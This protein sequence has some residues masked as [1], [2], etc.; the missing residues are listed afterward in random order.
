MSTLNPDRKPLDLVDP[1]GLVFDVVL[2]I[3]TLFVLNG[4]HKKGENLVTLLGP[5][6][7]LVF[8]FLAQIFIPPY[9]G[10]VWGRYRDTGGILF[11]VALI[12]IMILFVY[13]IA[14]LYISGL[15]LG[16]YL[17]RDYGVVPFVLALVV[18]LCATGIGGALGIK[19]YK[20]SRKSSNSSGPNPPIDANKVKPLQR[21]PGE[22]VRTLFVAVLVCFWVDFTV[23]VSTDMDVSAVGAFFFVTVSGVIPLRLLVEFQ[24]PRTPI[25]MVTGTASLTCFIVMV[26]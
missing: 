12:F 16:A 21:Q 18:G 17:N 19:H 20:A 3:F 25:S 15:L 4:L 22:S 8:M 2:V 10:R 24:P 23:L 26:V 9:A 11:G 13:T 5:V 14:L 1:N 6:F 7:G